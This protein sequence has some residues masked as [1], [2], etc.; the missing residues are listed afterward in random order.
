[1]SA[2]VLA[3]CAAPAARADR[4]CDGAPCETLVLRADNAQA[5][6]QALLQ[7]MELREAAQAAVQ[8]AAG[9]VHV[10]QAR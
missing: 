1:M 7:H 10:A 6:A 5:A 4:G 2:T 9:Q 8:E 3:P